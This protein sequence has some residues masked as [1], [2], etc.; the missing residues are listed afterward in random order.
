MAA[1][2]VHWEVMGPDG[3]A[4]VAFYQDLFGW[5]TSAPPGFEGYHLVPAEQSG[6]GGAVGQGSEEMPRYI[7]IYLEAESI[8]EQLARIE[9]AGGKTVAPR[10]VIPGMVTYALFA[11][12]AG[13]VVGLVESEMP[14][15]E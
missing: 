10:T 12:P 11:D 15:A 9:A 2:I 7:T 3:G 1:K 4:M 14:P 5:E 8:D 13:N 6:V